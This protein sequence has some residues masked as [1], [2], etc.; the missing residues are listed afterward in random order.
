MDDIGLQAQIDSVVAE[1]VIGRFTEFVRK[2]GQELHRNLTT[3]SRTVSFEYGSPVWTGRYSAS[4][5][6]S[7]ASPKYIQAPE[8]P[9]Q[10]TL[11]WPNEPSSR[12]RAVQ[13]AAQ[14]RQILTGLQPFQEIFITNSLPYS[15]VIE[16]GSS[17]KAPGGVYRPTVDALIDKY[18]NVRI[19][20]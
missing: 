3:D 2:I 4:H 10:N 15:R 12:V 11:I 1:K 7:I 16:N 18:R 14:V 17:A 6:V 8:H 19:K 13:T 20:L 5:I 9:Q